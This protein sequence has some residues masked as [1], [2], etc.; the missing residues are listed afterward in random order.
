MVLGLNNHLTA[1]AGLRTG[2]GK[3]QIT[4]PVLRAH[5]VSGD[6]DSVNVGAV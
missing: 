6:I 5:A 3:A 2:I 1:N 4:I